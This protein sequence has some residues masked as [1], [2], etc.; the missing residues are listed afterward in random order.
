MAIQWQS[1]IRAALLIDRRV[2]GAILISLLY[3]STVVKLQ[4]QGN[5]PAWLA[6][7]AN[8]IASSL[9]SV[10]GLLLAFRSNASASRWD[11][12]R[13]AWTEIHATCRALLRKLSTA[14]VGIADTSLQN[15]LE[16]Q[17]ELLH[18]P[19]AFALAVALQLF[20]TEIAFPLRRQLYD[21]PAATVEMLTLYSL[22][23]DRFFKVEAPNIPEKTERADARED[24]V[25]SA[26]LRQRRPGP[27]SSDFAANRQQFSE[28]IREKRL[29]HDADEIDFVAAIRPRTHISRTHASSSLASSNFALAI[30]FDLQS[31]L[32]E[33]NRAGSD[34]AASSTL[35]GSASQTHHLSGPIYAHCTNALNTLSSRLTELEALRDTTT[36]PTL[37]IHLSH[38]LVINQ[39]LLP[40]SLAPTLGWWTPIAAALIVYVYGALYQLAESLAQPFRRGD[41]NALPLRRW[42]AEV[43]RESREASEHLAS[44][45]R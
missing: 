43:V 36:P 15:R 31:R 13:K 26:T 34:T 18:L 30:L 28:R 41:L 22:L 37:R 1:S 4:L 24:G 11:A 42:A 39:L 12:S 6:N 3:S 40:V 21:D 27:T 32:D 19:A 23:P 35:S 20:G 16:S 17:Q 25:T 14:P 33:M 45:A 5:C 44:S 8:K 38:V 29:L 10:I 7:G 2:L 9:A